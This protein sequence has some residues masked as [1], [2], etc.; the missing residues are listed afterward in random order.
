MRHLILGSG[1]L[2]ADLF[3]KLSQQPK[4]I[5]ILMS[6]SNGLDVTT[7]K[8]LMRY[9]AENSF[10]CIWYCVGG[11]SVQEA[12][13]NYNLAHY[14]NCTLPIYLADSLPDNIKLVFF[15]S[16]YVASETEPNNPKR[17]VEKPLSLYAQ[18][19]LEMEKYIRATA[20]PN[21]S[22]VRVTSLYGHHKPHKTFPG[23]ILKNFAF[24]EKK[25]SLP[26]NLVTPTSTYWLSSI[27]LK[28][29]DQLFSDTSVVTH[30][31]APA[32]NVSVSD[33]GK[34]VL[35]EIRDRFCFVDEEFYDLERPKFSN[36]GCSLSTY[37]H[38]WFESFKHL[39]SPDQYIPKEYLGRLY[40]HVDNRNSLI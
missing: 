19:K 30:H 4:S 10:D 16:D 14:L 38:H 18:S 25:I 23:K 37:N 27:L 40:E 29:F 36:L 22:I 31:V 33:W 34:F 6:K 28:H 7:F 13:D 17:F 2:G 1:N 20:R 32:G 3:I 8:H 9:I 24:I 21:T 5:P 11:G 15:S 35:H 12:K 26:Q 39:Y